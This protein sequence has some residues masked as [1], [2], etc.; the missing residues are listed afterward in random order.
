VAENDSDWLVPPPEPGWALLHVAVDE[1][2]E[3]TP[4]LRGAIDALLVALEDLPVPAGAAEVEGFQPACPDQTRCAPLVRQP[5]FK[6]HIIS[7]T[8]VPC[9]HN[10]VCPWN[11][12]F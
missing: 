3:V 6:K 5:C 7:C 9:P 11:D 12:S 4:E 8:I 2:A 1:D 10:A